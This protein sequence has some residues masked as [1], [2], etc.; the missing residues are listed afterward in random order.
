V[1]PPAAW[2]A[3]ELARRALLEQGVAVAVNL[4]R[5]HALLAWA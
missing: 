3:D 2:T 1:T 4:R 5:H